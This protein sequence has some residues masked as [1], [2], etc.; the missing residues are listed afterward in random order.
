M[1][2]QYKKLIQ[3]IYIMSS[4]NHNSHISD[5]QISKTISMDST[6]NSGEGFHP[7]YD[8]WTFYAHLPHDTDWTMVQIIV[9]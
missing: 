7:L 3:D 8:K 2:K 5:I 9:I 1:I 4:L 6:N